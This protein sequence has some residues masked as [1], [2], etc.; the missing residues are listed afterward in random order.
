MYNTIKIEKGLYN[1]S[2][3]T[4]SQAL[5]AMDPSENYT[6]EA[7][8]KMDAFDRRYVPALRPR[9]TRNRPVHTQRPP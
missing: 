7:L 1:L 4:F 5:E 3:K 6:D 2:G 9:E 8:R